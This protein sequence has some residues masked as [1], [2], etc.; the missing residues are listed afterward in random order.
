MLGTD[1]VQHRPTVMTSPHTCGNFP[2]CVCA[3][4]SAARQPAT[5]N[6]SS[7]ITTASAAR[8]RAYC[9][10]AGYRCHNCATNAVR[11]SWHQHV[12]SEPSAS[13]AQLDAVQPV[14]LQ[15][16]PFASASG[17]SFFAVSDRVSPLS[18][19]LG[20]PN[21]VLLG[22]LML[23]QAI[24]LVGSY[25]TGTLARKRRVKLAQVNS[26]LRT[27]RDAL[28][29]CSCPGCPQSACTA[30]T[31]PEHDGIRSTFDGTSALHG[32]LITGFVC[33]PWL[34]HAGLVGRPGLPL[35]YVAAV[36]RTHW[37]LSSAMLLVV[38]QR[39]WSPTHCTPCVQVRTAQACCDCTTLS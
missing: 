16:A 2:S 38:S 29:C 3:S 24:T 35:C 30:A 9:G 8:P 39:H 20:V 13:A 37:C 7:H 14:E 31:L 36:T 1:I 10:E 33:N 32:Q 22:G 23:T 18:E 6:E 25:T 12:Q 5:S 26:K 34:Y 28:L 11:D 27:V 4:A 17:S 21:D 15:A 19:R